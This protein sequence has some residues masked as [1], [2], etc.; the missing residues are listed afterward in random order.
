MTT[1]LYHTDSYQRQFFAEVISRI[2]ESHGVIL[3]QT[4]FFPGG[5][6]QPA[7]HATPAEGG[8]VCPDCQRIMRFLGKSGA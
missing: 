4:A 1:R 3:N 6:G 2:E 7:A 5:G 8:I